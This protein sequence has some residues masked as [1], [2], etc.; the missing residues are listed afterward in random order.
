MFRESFLPFFGISQIS[1]ND[2]RVCTLQHVLIKS[3]SQI[4]SRIEDTLS[5]EI[6]VGKKCCEVTNFIY[7]KSG[8]P[9]LLNSTNY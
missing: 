4:E 6:I 9:L 1:K 2:Q 8:I 7:L 3:E 5:E